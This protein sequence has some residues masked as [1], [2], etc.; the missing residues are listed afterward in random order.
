M[1]IERF[2]PDKHHIEVQVFGNRV[3][4]AIHFGERDVLSS[5]DTR[6]SLKSVRAHSSYR[7]CVSV[8]I[9]FSQKK[10]CLSPLQASE[11]GFAQQPFT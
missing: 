8:P 9:N 1:F 11:K 7:T 3:G 6:K 5:G 4:N 10:S 2:Y